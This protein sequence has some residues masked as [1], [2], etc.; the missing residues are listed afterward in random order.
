MSK[1]SYHV[2]VVGATGAVGQKIIEL[3][4]QETK[5][6][7]AEVTFL[8]SKR[9]AGK[10]V[11]FKGREITIQEA[12]T[13]SFESVDIAFFSAGG[14]VSRQFVNHAVS[15]GAI[16]IDNTSEYRMVHDVPLVVPEVNSHT[17]K[18]H[19]GIIAVP[20]CSALQMVT[21]LQPIRKSFG[22]ERII[23]STYQAV[24]GSGIHAI[25]EL[26]EQAK[27][28]LTG[29]EVKSAILPVKKDKKHYPIAF[30]VLPQV[31]I[32]TDNDFTFEEVKMIQETKKILEDPNLKMAATCVRVPVVSGHSES[33]Y[34]ELEKETTV[35][36]IKEVLLD[37]PGVILQ[38][39]PSEQ[40]YP[41]PLYAEGKIDTFVGRIR[42]DPDTPKGFHL[43]IVSDNLLKGAAWNS[44][45]IAETLVQKGII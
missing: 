31:D 11:Q 20:N 25:H 12:K 22:L 42:K 10:K 37:A 15:S 41:M 36:E 39:N 9:S 8:S 17:L 44:V 33:V 18:E 28:M 26:K 45:Q 13:T 29:E 24:S 30:N 38:D 4:E 5:F 16:V 21:A 34:I 40:L 6:N 1:K 35:T 19:N 3:L 7:I 43:W 27:S 2:A 32:F 23:V 14:E